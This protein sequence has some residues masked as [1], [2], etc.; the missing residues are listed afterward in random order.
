MG[1]RGALAWILD[2]SDPQIPE[3]PPLKGASSV[4]TDD[5][6]GA[7]GAR[8]AGMSGQQMLDERGDAVVLL[9]R[10]IGVFEEVEISRAAD[11]S[12]FAQDEKG[13]LIE[14]L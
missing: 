4:L 10:E 3:L 7:R 12:H 1:S 2:V 14:F 13:L 5:G 11:S 6:T 8:L 9:A